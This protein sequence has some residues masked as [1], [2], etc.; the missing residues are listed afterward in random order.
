MLFTT[1]KSHQLQVDML[2]LDVLYIT[3]CTRRADKTD[4][5]LKQPATKPIY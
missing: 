4:S 3:W 5:G 1:K 2:C